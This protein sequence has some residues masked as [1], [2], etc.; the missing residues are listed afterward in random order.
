MKKMLVHKRLWLLLPVLLLAEWA[1]A[2]IAISGHVIDTLDNSPLIGVTIRE[3]GGTAGAV[4]DYEGNYKI[5]ISNA[6]ATLVFSYTGYATREVL[7]AGRTQVNLTMGEDLTTLQ[8]LVVMGYG[9]Q[10]K[11][12]LT[13]SVGTVKSKEIERV[14]TSSIEQA[15][16]GKVAG[17]YVTPA[18]GQPGAGAV[19]RIRG[20]GTLNNS[21]PLFVVDG[22]LL[23]DASFINPQDVQSIEILKDASATAI[24]G[25]RGAN[26]VVIITTK[27][28][29]AG[30]KAVIQFSS[31][32][33]TQSLTKKIPMANAAE[34]AQLY[35]ELP[36]PDVFANPASLG[37][38]T[39]WQDVIFRDAP[40]ANVQLSASGG[41]DKFLY[42]V[43]ANYFDQ[44]GILKD[45]RFDRL[46]FRVNNEYKLNP[47]VKLGNNLSFSNINSQN[48]PGVIGSA[49]Q[50][51]PVF[52][53]RDSLGNFSDPTFFGT[54]IA[55]PAADLFYKDRNFSKGTRLVG[56]VYADITLFK[57]FT[58]RSNFG[59]DQAYVNT[60]NY[61]PKFAVSVSQRNGEDRLSVG[62]VQRRTW[63]W[64]NTLTYDQTWENHHVNVLAGYTSQEFGD[65]ALG[66]SR[67]QFGSGQDELLYLNYGN[68]TTQLNYGEA[69][70]WAMISY[71]ARANYTLMDRY[72]LT[73]SM[74][75][76]G[77]SR[78]AADN[79]YGYFPSFA[80]GWNVA[81]ESFMSHQRFIDR[82]KLRAS[83]GIVG[84]DKT[85][86]YASL[87]AIQ[88]GLY[89]IFGSDESLNQGATLT[90][91]SNPNVRWEN[92]SQ[93]DV[94]MEIGVL[95]GRL[96]A[97]IDWYN[98]VTSDILA[99]LPIPD[100]V[101]SDGNPVVNS[102]KVRNRGW[103][104]T[105][106][107]RETRGKFTYNITG[108]LSTVDNEVL[109][110]SRGREEIFEASTAQGDFATRTV[111][112]QDIGSFYGYQ[113]AGV[114]QNTEE[115]SSLPKLG[116]EQPGDLRFADL[117]GRDSL[118]NL[119]GRPDGKITADD[120]TFLGSPIPKINYGF[121]VGV[122]AFGL[123]LAADFF[124]VSG[125][126]VLNAKAL[127][128]YGTYNWEK[129]FYDGRWT[130]EGTSNTTPRI[131]DG[132][133]NYRMSDYWIKDGSF[134]RLRTLVIGYTLP[135]DWTSNI[136]VSRARF[137]VSGTNLWTKQ[138]YSGY[139]PEF[140]GDNVYRVGIDNGSYPIAKTIL[141][142]LDVS[143]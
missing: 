34:Y 138:S 19:I 118:G 109:A 72:L 114:F 33:G 121:S 67:A 78:F 133:H 58:F 7:V 3:K 111:V 36:L 103:D 126:K 32:Y 40:I 108:I 26:G 104:F 57:H 55:N 128:R 122:E 39:D 48:P 139:S 54:A 71:L 29:K 80:L 46:T 31:Y 24:Y 116:G 77:S 59:L 18:S 6:D 76:D 63:L 101:G 129:F 95:N 65:E 130:G 87:G 30:E 94:G 85:Q 134:L 96:T 124:G 61:E 28:G 99:E 70:Q 74:R 143:F 98:R 47:Y 73:A 53:E 60:K 131:T 135:G 11:S 82:L 56:T 69:S 140:A 132:G 125:N 120:R 38:G 2:Q 137:Y 10:R 9:V 17:V 119:T 97:E 117:N 50:M 16:Q 42:N 45:S 93:T 20:T 91:L 43:S 75:V 123:D 110:L 25:N 112:G 68:D 5:S 4:T 27:R 83:W 115:L 100:Y 51:P 105:L 13:G 23:D 89:S 107:W 37:V 84:N 127:A 41:S 106:N 102:A 49:L 142:G 79:R 81:E 44:T 141:F 86:L 52:G 62:S 21:N 113:V 88:G 12:D 90:R 14:P 35:N 136:G 92:A 66:A 15:M 1:G 22:M 64:E 8:E